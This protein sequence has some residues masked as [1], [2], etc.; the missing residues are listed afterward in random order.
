MK[1]SRNKKGWLD[2][3]FFLYIQSKLRWEYWIKNKGKWIIKPIDRKI[4][5]TE[6]K[7]DGGVIEFKRRKKGVRGM[8]SQVK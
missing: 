8:E 6:R 2:N 3:H 1:V 5:W 4:Y 7:K